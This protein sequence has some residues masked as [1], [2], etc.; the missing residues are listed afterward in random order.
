MRAYI[1]RSSFS[2]EGWGSDQ[3]PLSGSVLVWGAGVGFF[4]SAARRGIVARSRIA[5]MR[6]A[7]WSIAGGSSRR[8][9]GTGFRKQGTGRTAGQRSEERE[10]VGNRRNELEEPR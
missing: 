2:V 3:G 7:R 8:K 9:H 10:E 6:L 5:E 1:V 4:L